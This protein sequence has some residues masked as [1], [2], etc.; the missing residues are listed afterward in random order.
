[1]NLI[2]LLYSIVQ[3]QAEAGNLSFLNQLPKFCCLR[4]SGSLKMYLHSEL[5]DLQTKLDNYSIGI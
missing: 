1:M 5:L 2:T 3:Y 4:S